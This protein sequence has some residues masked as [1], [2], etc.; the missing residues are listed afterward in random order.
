MDTRLNFIKEPL[1]IGGFLAFGL[2][3]Y[4]GRNTDAKQTIKNQTQCDLD[5]LGTHC[6][7]QIHSDT[8][9]FRKRY[10]EHLY[11]NTK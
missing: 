10:Y 9:D 2:T 1:F 11:V 7:T 8:T 3:F 6:V 4:F 5:T